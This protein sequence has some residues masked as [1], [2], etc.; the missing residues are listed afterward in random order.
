MQLDQIYSNLLR[1]FKNIPYILCV[2]YKLNKSVI[3]EIIMENNRTINH[4]FLK[5]QHY[6]IAQKFLILLLLVLL[7]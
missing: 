7:L 4:V 2:D 1:I 3:G 5:A 6:Q